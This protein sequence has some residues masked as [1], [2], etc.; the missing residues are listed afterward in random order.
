MFKSQTP[1][2]GATLSHTE[3]TMMNLAAPSISE[4]KP[5]NRCGGCRKKLCLTDFECR[6]K[7]RFCALHRAPEEHACPFD[8][9]SYGLAVLEK[10]LTK[11]VAD[12]VERF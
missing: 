7:V 2:V 12:K 5:T 9:K 11:A 6:C 1:N 4:T 3:P 8:F 10:Q